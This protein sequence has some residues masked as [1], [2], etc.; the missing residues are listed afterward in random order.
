MT[1]SRLSCL[2]A[3]YSSL[4]YHFLS[5]SGPKLMTKVTIFAL[6]RTPSCF[7]STSFAPQ[8]GSAPSQAQQ[9][10]PIH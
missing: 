8:L 1:L 4:Q 9:T 7:G 5:P 3:Q 2:Q 6:A 10:T